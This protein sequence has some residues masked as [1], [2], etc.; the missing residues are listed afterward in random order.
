M[1]GSE[2]PFF[3][4]NE[5]YR[6]FGVLHNVSGKTKKEGFIFCA[7]F[8]EEKLWAHRVFVSFARFLAEKGYPVLRFDY[9]GHGDSEGDFE[10][11]SVQTM[12][13]DINCAAQILQERI[14]S[15]ESLGFLGL[16]FGATLALLAASLENRPK[17]L[18]LWE[19]IIDGS[20]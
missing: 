19:P 11:S 5:G 10:I 1:K 20:V 2:L 3:F 8:A 16:R 6:L 12:I 7:P 4:L 9:M 13:S 15:I 14:P 17:K 18:I